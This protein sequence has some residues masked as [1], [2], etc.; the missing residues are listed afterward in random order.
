MPNWQ[1]LLNLPFFIAGFG[2]K[3][4][5]FTVK[6]LGITYIGG[7]LEGL[8]MCRKAGKDARVDFK[9]I[10]VSRIWSLEGELLVNVLR[11]F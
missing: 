4:L 3:A 1:I 7:L 9:R 5:F 11:R 2:I 10:P 8:R 6:G